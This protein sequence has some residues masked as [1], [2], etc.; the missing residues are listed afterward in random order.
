MIFI[1]GNRELLEKSRF[2]NKENCWDY[3]LQEI[4]YVLHQSE[5]NPDMIYVVCEDNRLYE[6]NCK[7]SELTE[8]Y[9]E[10]KQEQVLRKFELAFLSIYIKL[11]TNNQIAKANQEL[12]EWK[13]RMNEYNPNAQEVIKQAKII[14]GSFT[15]KIKDEEINYI[16]FV[17]GYDLLHEQLSN[18]KDNESDIIYEICKTISKDFLN[19]KYN[20]DNKSLY[21]CLV[22]YIVDN[23]FMKFINPEENKGIEMS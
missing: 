16:T 23:Q 6:T 18:S 1:L 10:L 5:P 14:L 4:N 12:E 2:Y 19:S 8:L 21:D 9:D 13:N 7:E 11:Y 22:D 15:E 17:L 20:C 3:S